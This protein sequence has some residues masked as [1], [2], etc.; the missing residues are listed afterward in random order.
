M[1]ECT[2]FLP[3]KTLPN[4]PLLIGL[5]ISKSSMQGAR[6]VEDRVAIDEVC[7]IK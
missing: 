4:A 5:I 6:F 7:E 3:K 2:Y 1:P